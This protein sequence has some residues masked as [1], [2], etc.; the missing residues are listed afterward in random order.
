MTQ[1]CQPTHTSGAFEQMKAT[2]RRPRFASIGRVLVS[3]VVAAGVIWFVSPGRLAES[4]SRLNWPAL[5][6]ATLTLVVALYLADAYCVRWL[7]TRG[8]ERLGYR[9]A[10]QARG[11]SY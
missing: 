3:I 5:V 2:L 11:S 6:A 10:L 1:E 4:A 7:F 8:D 9:S